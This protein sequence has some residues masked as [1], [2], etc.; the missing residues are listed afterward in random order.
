M[1]LRVL[2]SAAGGGFPQWN[3]CCYNCS[4]VRDGSF[5]GS[6]RSQTQLA[7]SADAAHWFLIQASPDLRDQISACQAL[8]PSSATFRASPIHGV[9]LTSAELDAALGLL[10]M[11]ESQPL[12]V[13]ATASVRMLL[14]EENL[15][16]GVLRRQSDQ[17]RW[18]VISPDRSFE[19]RTIQNESTGIR[20]TPVSTGG[21]YPGYVP[22]SRAA[23]LD[24]PSAVVGLF[25]EHDGKQIAFFPGAAAI[26]PEWLDRMAACDVVFFDGT[27]WSDDE[28]I[29]I[30]TGAKTARQMGHLP[31]ADTGGSLDQLASL[32]GPRKIYIHINNTN[33]MLDEG[34]TEF[35]RIRTAGWE[36]ATDGMALTL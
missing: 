22:P 4:R 23:G 35:N 33:P 2:G 32:K 9:V 17:I 1:Y 12:A 20:C 26:L 7:I 36:L 13:Y 10:L 24:T 28:L 14:V 31:V 21:G 29:R 19:L 5:P 8:H 3:C 25:V 27:F 34:S 16:F 11:R 15:V 30:Q 18:Q 6:A